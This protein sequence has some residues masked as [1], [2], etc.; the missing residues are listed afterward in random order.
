MDTVS[1]AAVGVDWTLPALSVAMLKKPYVCPTWPVKRVDGA[2]GV[3][4]A[5]N[6]NGPPSVESKIAKDA[7]PEAAPPSGAFGSFPLTETWKL[8]DV[9]WLGRELIVLTGAVVSISHVAVSVPVPALPA[10]SAIFEASNLNTYE[11]CRAVSA[12]SPPI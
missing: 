2:A 10:M 11:P 5:S 12:G 7:I 9:V 1:W 6:V 8:V 4:V 3:T